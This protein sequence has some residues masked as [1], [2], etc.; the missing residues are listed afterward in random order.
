MKFWWNTKD[1][2]AHASFEVIGGSSAAVFDG[3][4]VNGRYTFGD[5]F[6]IE[7]EL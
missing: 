1:D 2:P 5:D 7:T 4:A 6:D 3:I